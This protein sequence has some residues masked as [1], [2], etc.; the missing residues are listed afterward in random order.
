MR[1]KK[2]LIVISGEHHQEISYQE[3]KTRENNWS[4]MNYE[5]IKINNISVVLMDR[6]CLKDSIRTRMEISRKK[7]IKS[8]QDFYHQ[9]LGGTEF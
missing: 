9:R 7:N 5:D 6:K 3:K 4:S 8:S 1:N 2:M